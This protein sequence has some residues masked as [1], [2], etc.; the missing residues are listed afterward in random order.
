MVEDPLA[1]ISFSEEDEDKVG[2]SS[3][4]SPVVG[5]DSNTSNGSTYLA[6]P[7]APSGSCV[8]TSTVSLAF[9]HM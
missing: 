5:S 9:L 6:S 3:S 7:T 1:G 8:D 4:W 2:S